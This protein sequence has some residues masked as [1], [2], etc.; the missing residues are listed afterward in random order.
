MWAP[1]AYEGAPV[2]ITAYLAVGSK[3]AAF[4]LIVRLF[5][6]ALVP[7]AGDLQV[8]M[9]VL[10][11]LTMVLGNLV[12]LVQTNIKR[13][14]AYSSVGH[15]G[16][17]LLGVA[18]LSALDAG[19]SAGAGRGIDGYALVVSGIMLHIVAYAVTNMA[20]FLCVSTVYDA[21][22]REDTAAY[23]GL[24]SRSPGLAMVMAASLF[25]L[26]GL[27]IFAG[28]VSKFYLFNAAAFSGLLWLAGLAIAASLDIAV[29]LPHG[30][31]A[32]VRRPCR[33][34]NEAEGP[35]PHN[36]RA[37]G[38]VRGHNPAGRL[39]RTP[40]ARP[41]STPATR[42][43]PS[44]RCTSGQHLRSL[45]VGAD[46]VRPPRTEPSHGRRPAPPAPTPLGQRSGVGAGL[47]PASQ[48]TG[49]YTD[50]IE[51]S[52]SIAPIPGQEDTMENPREVDIFWHRI[53]HTVDE[54]VA[55]LEGL[56]GDSL[57]WSP[58]DDANSLYVLATHTMGNVRHNLLNVLCGLP[59]TRD[60]DAEFVATGGS[61]AE[62]EARWNELK[63]RIEEAIEDLPAAELDRDRR[64]PHR[65]VITGREVLAVV[66]GH[67][68]EH[69][70][71]AQLT[72]DLVR[73]TLSS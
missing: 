11:A 33:G 63:A 16:Y 15:V 67:A 42:C 37:C 71:Q 34:R 51:K 32:H 27:P 22:G 8:V 64:H 21:T 73:A 6:D 48:A 13:L 54:L 45:P 1:D 30:H 46:R 58:L 2:P 57:N 40:H 68:A 44:R 53:R 4:A 50:R 35:P 17:L 26:A 29:L 61:A 49:V 20:A 10:A 25:S 24:A 3:A 72:R 19:G 47:K 66:A 55:C 59:I 60:R 52:A 65:G 70:G 69:Y 5:I 14:L 28:F 56:D 62:I 23:S 31:Q 7:A 41:S 43:W 9:A 38:A 36:G 39:P 12:A 18:A